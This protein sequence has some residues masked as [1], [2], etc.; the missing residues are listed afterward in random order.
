MSIEDR[1]D[2]IHSAVSDPKA[3]TDCERMN[4]TNFDAF[5]LV[6]SHYLGGS[7]MQNYLISQ[8]IETKLN[9]LN[10]IKVGDLCDTIRGIYE[11]CQV[12]G[13][14]TDDLTKN[15][16]DT[17]EKY[18]AAALGTVENEVSPRALDPPLSE[19]QK[20]Y[21][22]AGVLGGSREEERVVEKMKRFLLRYIK[23]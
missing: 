8:Q 2:V 7:E 15:F 22:I 23:L 11:A 16:W 6:F 3:Y 1:Y 12:V 13:R 19:L 14:P 21:E 4:N 5:M 20:Y 9:A 18:E 17:H 10:A